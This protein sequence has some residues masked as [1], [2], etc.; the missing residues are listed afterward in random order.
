MDHDPKSP[1]QNA[2]ILS[3]RDIRGFYL[4]GRWCTENPID[5]L[6]LEQSICYYTN[7]IFKCIKLCISI[8]SCQHTLI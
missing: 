4:Q 7:D 2:A 1:P 5:T 8:I 3:A 6:P